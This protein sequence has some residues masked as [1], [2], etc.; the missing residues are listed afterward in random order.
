M[1]LHTCRGALTLTPAS[2]QSPPPPTNASL[3]ACIWRTDTYGI[4]EILLTPDT[5]NSRRPAS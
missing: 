2:S 3:V 5:Q 4:A 1:P